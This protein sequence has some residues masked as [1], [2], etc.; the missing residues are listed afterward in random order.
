[1]ISLVQIINNWQLTILKDFYHHNASW[2]FS[3]G[4]K[5]PGSLGDEE[6]NKAG[7]QERESEHHVSW[8][9]E[10]WAVES[11]IS[12]SFYLRTCRLWEGMICS[13]ERVWVVDIVMEQGCIREQQRCWSSMVRSWIKYDGD[14][15][16]IVDTGVEAGTQYCM[17]VIVLQTQWQ[18]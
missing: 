5:L 17:V 6:N 4:L 16:S 9:C 18:W 8:V 12:L 10:G 14:I 1:M 15:W 11:I 2:Y 7:S 3:K 13:W